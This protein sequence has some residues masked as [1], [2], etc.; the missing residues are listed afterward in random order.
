MTLQIQVVAT[1]FLITLFS[2]NRDTD[3]DMLPQ[4]TLNCSNITA[5]TTLD[6]ANYVVDC[7]IDVRN[8]AVL[9]IQ[10]GTKFTFTGN[11]SMSTSNGGAIKAI[12]AQRCP[13]YVFNQDQFLMAEQLEWQPLTDEQIHQKL[14]RH[15]W[16]I[17][18][19]LDFTAF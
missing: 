10:P 17:K 16:E 1:L 19:L 4:I 14:Y 11:G 18:L 6:V 7:N 3:S 9:T 12:G 5:S 13:E 15:W 8:G 2:C